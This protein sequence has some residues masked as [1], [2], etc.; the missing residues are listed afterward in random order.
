VRRDAANTG[1]SASNL[2]IELGEIQH[3]HAWP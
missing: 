3:E 1:A 2:L